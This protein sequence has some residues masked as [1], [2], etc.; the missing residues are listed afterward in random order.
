MQRQARQPAAFPLRPCTHVLAAGHSSQYLEMIDDVMR[1]G[2]LRGDRTGTGTYSKFGTTMRFN[3]RHSFPLLTS[4]RVFWRG[5]R[6]AGLRR[7]AAVWRV[8]PAL[9]R[10]HVQPHCLGVRVMR[11]ARDIAAPSCHPSAPA[12]RRLTPRSTAPSA[13]SPQVWPRSCCGL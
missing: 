5:G 4:K 3:L 13:P 12:C 10:Q 1:S 6:R 7:L 9:T 11:F 8:S 2:V